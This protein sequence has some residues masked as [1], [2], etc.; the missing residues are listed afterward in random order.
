VRFGEIELRAVR[1]DVPVGL[2]DVWNGRRISLV[3]GKKAL[4][5]EP[6]SEVEI[7][8]TVIA[9]ASYGSRT[10]AGGRT[11]FAEKKPLYEG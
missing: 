4:D 7:A 6:T 2:P 9:G 3:V 10:A 5:Y 1:D 11:H 8:E